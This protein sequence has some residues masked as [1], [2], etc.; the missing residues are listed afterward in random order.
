MYKIAVEGRGGNLKWVDFK[1]ERFSNLCYICGLLGYSD[2]NYVIW[3]DVGRFQI[4]CMVIF[5][6]KVFKR[7]KFGVGEGVRKGFEI[8]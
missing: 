1:F 7:E 2:K 6:G 5:Y 3:D 4:W 8:G